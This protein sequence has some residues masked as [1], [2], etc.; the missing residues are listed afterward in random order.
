MK[1]DLAG[2][3]KNTQL[4]RSR[5]LLPLFEAVVNSLQ[6]IE[7]AG[8]NVLSPAITIKVERDRVLENLSIPGTVNG[9]AVSDNGI[10]FDDENLDSFFTSDTQHKVRKGGK[11]IGRFSWLKAFDRVH[12]ESHFLND[13]KLLKRVF[14]FTM[15]LDQP[16]GPAVPSDQSIP[17]TAVQLT[18]MK[19]PYR[20]SCPQRLQLIGHQLIEHCLPFFI[21][22]K[23]PSVAIYDDLDRIDLNVY[24]RDNFAASAT[25]HTFSVKDSHFTLTGIRLY[26]P[27]DNQHRLLYAANFREVVAEK[28]E[29][30]LPNLERRLTDSDGNRF[31]YLGFVEG[32]YLDQSANGERTAFSFPLERSSDAL[33]DEITLDAIR[34]PSVDCV[35]QDLGSFLQE[36]NTEKREAINVYIANEAPEYRP[37]VRYIDEFID[38]IP[39][40]AT[41]RS[42]ECRFRMMK[43]A[44]VAPLRK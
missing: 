3:I 39:P 27:H 42:L 12:I 8:E 19:S 10:G 18:G 38:R 40:G 17:K 32:A 4:P 41:G 31:V 23:C 36:I 16:P 9:F 34:A 2:K 5:A 43:Q 7:D 21:D 14:D 35:T 37:L 13:G 15:T 25:R 24:F 29:R 26:N 20:D 30:Y 33:F 22:P 1:V 28:L 6:A 11:G 44:R